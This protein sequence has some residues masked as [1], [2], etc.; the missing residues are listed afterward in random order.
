VSGVLK[1]YNRSMMDSSELALD[2]A[3]A[4]ANIPLTG[5]TDANFTR[6]PP[7]ALS[8][9]PKA[10]NHEALCVVRSRIQGTE[11]GRI[12]SAILLGGTSGRVLD[13]RA[14]LDD[15]GRGDGPSIGGVPE[16]DQ[17]QRAC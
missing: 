13:R 7:L 2:F 15:A 12:G 17:D 11:D 3:S 16:G 1:L 4:S 8:D 5:T 6:V 9:T 14:P 10:P